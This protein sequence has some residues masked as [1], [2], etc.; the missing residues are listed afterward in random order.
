M[1]V[2][3]CNQLHW[4]IHWLNYI[5]T[6]EFR[7]FRSH[8]RSERLISTFSFAVTHKCVQ[9]IVT[10]F[11]HLAYEGCQKSRRPFLDL[12]AGDHRLFKRGKCLVQLA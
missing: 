6:D 11:L 8:L 1:Q 2:G 3:C 4:P 9:K 7:L 5:A 12:L 10:N